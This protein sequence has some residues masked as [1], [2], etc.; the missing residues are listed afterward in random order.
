MQHP[1][2]RHIARRFL[3]A[4]RRS[5]AAR[6]AERPASHWASGGVNMTFEK[7]KHGDC[8]HDYC[9]LNDPT[10]HVN[11]YAQGGINRV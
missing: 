6:A 7:E 3:A 10:C 2:S 8:S 1:F 9:A 11:T 5:V 4:G